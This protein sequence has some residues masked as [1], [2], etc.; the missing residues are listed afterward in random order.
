MD[1][2]I[3][4]VCILQRVPE[5][6]TKP[7]PLLPNPDTIRVFHGREEIRKVGFLVFLLDWK[8]ILVTPPIIDCLN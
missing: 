4:L 7:E 2:K 8:V 6:T 5:L 3:I 1:T